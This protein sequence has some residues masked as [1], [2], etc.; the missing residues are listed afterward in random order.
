[1]QDEQVES[2][3]PPVPHLLKLPRELR[4]QIYKYVLAGKKWFFNAEGRLILQPPNTLA[5]LQV[6]RQIYMETRL[7]PLTS[8]TFHASNSDYLRRLRPPSHKSSI[9]FISIKMGE[10][11]YLGRNGMQL[12]LP[13]WCLGDGF[14]MS[15]FAG[16]KRLHVYLETTDW[17]LSRTF[18]YADSSYT[19]KER[20]L[21]FARTAKAL[22]FVRTTFERVNPGVCVTIETYVQRERGLIGLHG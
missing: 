7:I 19:E 16:L 18:F 20:T 15:E 11:T 3:E 13:D 17:Q 2:C 10:R 8:S 21:R 5:L 1:M 12:D 14:D 4:D 9:H 22:N 6:C